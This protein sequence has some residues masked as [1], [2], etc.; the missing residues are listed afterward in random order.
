VSIP[1]SWS[2]VPR[3]SLEVAR[4]SVS[5]TFTQ[6]AEGFDRHKRKIHVYLCAI[7]YWIKLSLSHEI[8]EENG[9][10]KQNIQDRYYGR[11][12]PVAKKIL[13]EQAEL[14]G[15]KVPEDKTIVRARSGS[16]V[17]AWTWSCG[18]DSVS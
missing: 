17:R 10:Q 5:L 4:S 2:S 15:M 6:R 18:N 1:V 8:P 16:L 13:R 11:N 7:K 3:V 14:K 9:L 12:D